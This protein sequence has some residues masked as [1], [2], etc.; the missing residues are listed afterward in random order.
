MQIQKNR[1]VLCLLIS[2]IVAILLSTL[3]ALGLF[4]GWQ[5]KLGDA[6][7]KQKEPLKNIVIVA[8]DDA[9]LQ[10]IGRWPWPRE[11]F[12][13]L[14]PKLSKSEVIGIDIA[15]FENY[16][17]NI[18]NKLGEEIKKLGNVILPV[19]YTKFDQG[20]GVEILK[21]IELI[22]KGAAGIGAINVFSDS[23][24]I[25]RAVPL[26]IS[27]DE[28]K[29]I[30]SYDGFTLAIYKQLFSRNLSYEGKTNRF[31]INFVGPPASFNTISFSDV[32]NNNYQKDLFK[33]AIVLIGATSPDLHDDYFVPTSSGKSMPGVELHAN[34]LQTMITKQF[35]QNES[36]FA[37]I[38][39]IFAV[40]LVVGLLLWKFRLLFAA[41]GS[42]MLIFACALIAMIMFNKGII[43][44]IFYPSLSILL[45]YVI[46]VGVYYVFAEKGRKQVLNLFGKYVSKEVVNEI[47]KNAKEGITQLKGTEREVT[48][49]F[50]DIRGFTSISE[51]LK[52]QEVVTMLNTYLGE[53]TNVVFKYK[54]TLDKFIGD[55]IMAIFNAPVEQQNSALLA[56]R[57]ALEMQDKIKRIHTV[58]GKK[59][60]IMHAGIG[61][62]T[63]HAVIGNIG[64]KERMEYTAI[65][66]N[67]N[68]ASRLCGF[69]K[70]GQ[71]VISQSTYNLVKD[72][73][74]AKKL[75]EIKVKNKAKPLTVYEV[76][77][78]K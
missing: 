28:S 31:L 46:T 7:Y 77:S 13:E 11:R 39:T 17:A 37:I 64:T 57:A 61:I 71:V 32:L 48:I 36:N 21:T 41:M 10:E 18:D 49:L 70:G 42:L 51:K 74:V 9:S 6:L 14:L 43:A 55:C 35:L 65:G 76:K 75:G 67:V 16:N 63:G 56:V 60:P 68:L 52:P 38:L 54:G 20:K 50:A 15:F 78:L 62:N 44:N 2:G 8:I 23:D 4:S 33:N 26:Q 58:H 22:R 29:E 5:M 3:F 45:T 72:K 34:A 25:T 24:G 66:D 27:G 12:L 53:M 59:I 1:L 69:A 40:S 47:M 19:E 73:I 30:E